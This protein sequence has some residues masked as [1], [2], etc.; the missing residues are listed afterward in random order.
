LRVH[1]ASWPPSQE[2]LQKP[3]F[4][5]SRAAQQQQQRAWENWERV[6]L[7]EALFR[8]AAMPPATRWAELPS[9]P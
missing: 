1:P 4:L 6:A 9:F 2:L 7:A 8:A 3:A 5:V